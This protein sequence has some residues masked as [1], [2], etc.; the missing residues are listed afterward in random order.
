M[1]T[2]P[3]LSPDGSGGPE[4]DGILD[5]IVDGRTV[6]ASLAAAEADRRVTPCDGGGRWR[7]AKPPRPSSWVKLFRDASRHCRLQMVLFDYVYRG[8]RVPAGCESCYK[9]KVVPR[10]LR[11]L[12]AVN[13]I[14][15]AMPHT[16]KCGLDA[17]A[18]LTSGIYG[19]FL[20]ARAG[21]GEGGWPGGASGSGRAS[22]A[23]SGGSGLREARMYRIRG[24]ARA[25]G[26]VH[27]RRGDA[28]DRAADSAA[29][30]DRR[31]TAGDTGPAAA[32]LRPLDPNGVRPG[33]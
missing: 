13:G 11:E 5:R 25:V 33:G 16:F 8:K 30:P 28:G 17:P 21:G 1:G 26:P 7:I 2:A 12:V 32:D 22:A 18:P 14:G 27:L 23:G 24:A 31:G 15:E 6:R 3:R 29:V 4:T 19:L 9:V 20:P 10:T